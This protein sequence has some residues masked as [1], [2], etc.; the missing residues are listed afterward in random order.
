MKKTGLLLNKQN[1]LHAFRQ[2]IKDY[3]AN[4]ILQNVYSKAGT[5][6]SWELR[7][8]LLKSFYCSFRKIII[9]PK[10]AFSL[11]ERLLYLEVH[12]YVYSI[13]VFLFQG[14][15]DLWPWRQLCIVEYTFLV[16]GEI[17]LQSKGWKR[18]RFT[19][20]SRRLFQERKRRQLFL[21]ISK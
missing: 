20:F 12:F 16:P 18:F 1:S 9:S 15:K 7:Q 19:T 8:L 14:V 11:S 6:F 5:K 13:M 3:K 4:K 2:P 21:F 17:Y 10:D